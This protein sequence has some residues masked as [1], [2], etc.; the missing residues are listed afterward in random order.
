MMNK[1]TP[2]I[3]VAGH[4]DSGKTALVESLV[5]TLRQK[6][7]RVAAVKHVNQTGFSLD[8]KGKDTWRYSQAGA[9][10]VVAVSDIETGILIRDGASHFSKEKLL[11][12]LPEIDC[13]ILEGFSWL[14]LDDE[15]VGKII[16]VRNRE[17]YE[18][19]RAAAKGT[20]IAFCSLQTLGHPI[21]HLKEDSKRLTH[22]ASAFIAEKL[23][24]YKIHSLLP[25]LDCGKCGYATCDEMAGAINA[26]TKAMSDCI[27]LK[28]RSA[29]KT[30]IMVDNMEVPIQPFVS[31]IIS[32]SVLGMVS[33]LKGVTL[34]SNEKVQIIITR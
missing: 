3:A 4:K 24:A 1:R 14:T 27:P 33:S 26:E 23:K 29:L 22:L 28:L 16:C 9:D 5:Q 10:P 25:G 7:R 13:L 32:N 15:Q 12:L 30:K 20:V 17:E 18:N 8:T 11:R 34:S 6:K 2:A 19:Y 31:N 21:L